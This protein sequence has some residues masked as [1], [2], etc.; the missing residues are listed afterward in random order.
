M[1]LN[2]F[3][4]A[5]NKSGLIS[6]GFDANIRGKGS[7][8][9]IKSCANSINNLNCIGA[10]LL[11]HKQSNCVASQRRIINFVLAKAPKPA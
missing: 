6:N 11:L 4:S 5:P 9:F 3:N 2:F 8:K 7:H 1:A 10:C